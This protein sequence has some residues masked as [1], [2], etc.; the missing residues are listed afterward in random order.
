VHGQSLDYRRQVIDL[1]PPQPVEVVEH[2]VITRWCPK[3]QRWRSPQLALTGQVL[4]QGRIGVRIA[5]L[6]AFLSQTLRLPIRRIPAYL[7]RIHQLTLS[8][9]EIVELLHHVRR[10]LQP[11]VETLKQ[12]ARAAPIL[13]GAETAGRENGG[14]GYIWAFA[15]PGDEAV[16]Y[17]DYDRSR[18][19]QVGR[20]ILDGVFAGHL[21]SDF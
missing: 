6:I 10:T 17:D 18:S 9:G 15:T 3:C 8:A 19:Q 13:H 5:S 1:P 2:L 14:N 20:R 4:G 12:P 21:V 7:H 11:A 16:R